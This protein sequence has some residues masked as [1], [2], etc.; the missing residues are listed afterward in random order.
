MEVG[1]L[2]LIVAHLL[3]VKGGHRCLYGGIFDM[4]VGGVFK[5]SMKGTKPHD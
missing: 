4:M 1:S 5:V 2:D 3:S